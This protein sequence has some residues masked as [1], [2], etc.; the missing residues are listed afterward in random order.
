[1]V[2]LGIDV[3]GSGVKGAIVDTDKGAMMSERH[4][5]ATPQPAKPGPLVETFAQI[6]KHFDWK[7]P[8]GCGFPAP[9]VRGKVKFAANI[10]NQSSKC[11]MAA[12][13]CVPKFRVA[14]G[15]QHSRLPGAWQSLPWRVGS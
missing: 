9:I 4:R 8:V 12:P 15:I 6:V 13:P 1:M 5:I 7:G 3:G 2:I 10:S 14:G 11:P